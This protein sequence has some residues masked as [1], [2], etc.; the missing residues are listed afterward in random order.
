[1]KTKTTIFKSFLGI[2]LINMLLVT[3]GLGQVTDKI[4]YQAVI[5]DASNE[6]VREA[7]IGVRISILKG[8]ADGAEIY[9]ETL[10]PETNA[11]G[12]VII[13][14]GEQL[15]MEDI[16]RAEG[17]YFIKTE[18]DPTGGS[19]YTIAGT[20][21]IHTVPFAI[22]S[23]TAETLRG[24]VTAD[25]IQV[26]TSS[27]ILAID[28]VQGQL[29][30]NKTDNVLLIFA[31]NQWIPLSTQDCWPQ[32]TPANAG[33]NQTFTDGTI[34]TIL[35]ANA[36]EDGYGI[37][38]WSISSGEGGSFDDVN[39]PNALFTGV[40]NQIYT[41]Q[42]SI[43][44]NCNT[45]NDE[46]TIYLSSG[47]DFSTEV[48]DVTNPTT[49]KTWMDRNLGASRAAISSTDAEAYGDLYQWG[50]AADWHQKRTSGTTSTLS[51]FDAPGHGNFI[52]VNSSPY[53]WRSP[54]NTNLWQGV[55]G[56]NNPCPTG[57]RLPTEAELNAERLS[58][59]SNN[60][61][62]AFASPLKLPVAGHRN[63]SNGS[64]VNVGILGHYW[65][66]NVD[67]TNSRQL[68]FGSSGAGMLSIYRAPGIAVRCLKD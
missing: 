38:E 31:G 58:W 23:R 41:L 29:V 11:N 53:D 7:Q 42:W 25:G 3:N 68:Y 63:H 35:N 59:S 6:L 1:M 37:G 19:N 9:S 14:F 17:P 4:S 56:T 13:E 57:Y 34:S 5:R 51:N 33:N 10:T 26:L 2:M 16:A 28:P 20:S 15:M 66:S 60:T 21:Q 40:I 64:L 62:G 50:R 45:S 39:N 18:I 44:T 55:N 61:A 27:E 22:H 48:V 8:A 30:F 47:T 32:P 65:S 67:G 49:G 46:L 43:Q 24:G 12:L 52:M 36:P 54:Q